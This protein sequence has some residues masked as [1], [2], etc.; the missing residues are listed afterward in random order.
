VIP[1]SPPLCITQ[2]E[3]DEAVERFVRALHDTTPELN[4]LAKKAA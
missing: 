3:C 1:F 4:R 2:A